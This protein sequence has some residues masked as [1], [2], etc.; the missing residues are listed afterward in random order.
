MHGWKLKV[1]EDQ[2]GAS[3]IYEVPNHRKQRPA[4][5][6][7][8]ELVQLDIYVQPWEPFRSIDFSDFYV[9]AK[10]P[11][12]DITSGKIKSGTASKKI[13]FF[14]EKAK[15]ITWSLE[16]S[17]IISM[18]KVYMQGRTHVKKQRGSWFLRKKL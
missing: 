17:L 12:Y 11:K 1:E 8:N 16:R 7:F 3:I 15:K 18:N 10:P 9:K 4:M 13:T 5:K 2:W 14:F 6:I